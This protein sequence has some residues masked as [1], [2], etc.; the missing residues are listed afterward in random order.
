MAAR[1]KR[2]GEPTTGPPGLI[3]VP[4]VR[5]LDPSVRGNIWELR[6]EGVVKELLRV[7]EE[8]VRV[9]PIDSGRPGDF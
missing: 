2:P 3:G 9:R 4:G 5:G 8:R 6:R 7:S 1:P